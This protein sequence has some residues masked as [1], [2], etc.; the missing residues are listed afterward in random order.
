MKVLSRHVFWLDK[1]LTLNLFKLLLLRTD[2]FPAIVK[3]LERKQSKY[4]LH[5]VK[6]GLLTIAVL[7]VLGEIAAN[8][9]SSANFTIM[10]DETTDI[11]N[12]EQF[13]LVLRWVD[14]DIAA[15]LLIRSLLGC[16][17]QTPS[18]PM[19]WWH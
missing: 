14:N 6:N 4:I 16:T 12:K 13:V 9:Q 3:Y 1:D 7:Q 18:H 8:L 19:H 5:D 17:R 11:S 15:M 10:V 2:D